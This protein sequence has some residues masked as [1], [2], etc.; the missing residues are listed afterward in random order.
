MIRI[1]LLA[2]VAAF[3]ASSASASEVR[4]SLVGK[5]AE[6]INADILGAARAVCAKDTAGEVL[7]LGAYGRCVRDT[8]QVTQQKL[9]AL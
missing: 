7:V 4:V 6:Q 3:A 1:A 2:A 9:A 5:S 8:V